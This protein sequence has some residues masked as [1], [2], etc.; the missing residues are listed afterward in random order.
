MTT[1]V[2]D[3]LAVSLILISIYLLASAFEK[4]NTIYLIAGV[5]GALITILVEVIYLFQA[6]RRR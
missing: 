6:W 4:T 3:F 5:S 2:S 1:R